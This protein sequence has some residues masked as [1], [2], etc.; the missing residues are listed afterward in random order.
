VWLNRRGHEASP[1]VLAAADLVVESLDE[2]R[3]LLFA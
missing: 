2:L 1:Q 3:A